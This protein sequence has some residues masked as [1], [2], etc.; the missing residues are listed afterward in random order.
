MLILVFVYQFTSIFHKEI[1]KKMENQDFD[2]KYHDDSDQY[3][4]SESSSTA[5]EKYF[6]QK[7]IELSSIVPGSNKDNEDSMLADTISYIKS[8]QERCNILEEQNK[9]TIITKAWVFDDK[10]VEESSFSKEDLPEIE[11]KV[12][13]KYVLIR[14]HCENQKGHLTKVHGIIEKIHLNVENTSSLPFGDSFVAITVTAQ[15][16]DEFF[17]TIEDL[18]RE[19]REGLQ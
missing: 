14:V 5:T 19:L 6:Q 3:S 11:A 12:E 7:I 13:E 8:L 2:G 4:S 1:A 16:T 9:I 17:I 15:M 10:N 18:K